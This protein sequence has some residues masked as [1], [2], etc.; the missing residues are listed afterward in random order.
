VARPRNGGPDQPRSEGRFESTITPEIVQSI[1]TAVQAGVTFQGAAGYAGVPAR[2]FYRW[3]YDGR[4][5]P[6]NHPVEATLIAGLDQALG[7][8]E[9]TAMLGI[10]QAA[11][12]SWQAWAWMLERRFPDRYSRMVKQD[13]SVTEASDDPRIVAL[14][15]AGF[16]GDVS[17]LDEEDIETLLTIMA[18]AIPGG[19]APVL[20]AGDMAVIEQGGQ[21]GQAA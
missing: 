6:D 17:L 18:K 19:Q 3:L 11:A 13:V 1:V 10:R 15:K 14:H 8:F 9:T 20:G 16:E 4:R 7:Q 21:N 12:N 5:D 2:T